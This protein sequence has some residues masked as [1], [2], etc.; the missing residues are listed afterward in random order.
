MDDETSG[1]SGESKDSP[2]QVPVGVPDGATAAAAAASGTTTGRVAADE[3]G[4]DAAGVSGP[5][6]D[7]GRQF[8]GQPWPLVHIF[9][10]EMWERF[11]FY[12]MQGILLLYMY[13]TVAEGGL[14]IDQV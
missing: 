9:G 2:E 10:V 3:S 13:Y 5:G 4:T 14:G 1:G 6:V 11:S 7:S 8:F 12:G